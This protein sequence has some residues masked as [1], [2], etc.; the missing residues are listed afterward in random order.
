[1]RDTI[2][3]L[4]TSVIG[5]ANTTGACDE[6]A[7][8]LERVSALARTHTLTLT[9]ALA[10][11]PDNKNQV[12]VIKQYFAQN[13]SPS[14]SILPA[15]AVSDSTPPQI[16]REVPKKS[17]ERHLQWPLLTKQMWR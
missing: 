13:K 5:L 11:G 17:K 6:I 12:E 3:E 15:E 7:S 1:M 9:R 8:I 2:S 4:E 16:Q 10:L 14:N